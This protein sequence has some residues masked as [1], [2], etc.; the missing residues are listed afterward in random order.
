[1]AVVLSSYRL[2]DSL[3]ISLVSCSSHNN[4]QTSMLAF[5]CLRCSPLAAAKF[6]AVYSVVRRWSGEGSRRGGGQFHLNHNRLLYSFKKREGESTSCSWC[7]DLHCS[8]G[9]GLEGRVCSFY[10]L[11]FYIILVNHAKWSRSIQDLGS[12]VFGLRNSSAWYM[13]EAF[14]WAI[15]TSYLTF[16]VRRIGSIWR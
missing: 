4:W 13:A 9:G 8:S 10:T 12:S 16:P 1:M 6:S 5:T 11:V 15:E 2:A 3:A 14:I 7:L